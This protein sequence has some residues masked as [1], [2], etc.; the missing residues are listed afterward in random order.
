M[1]SITRIKMDF[2][3]A[4]DDADKIDRIASEMKKLSR[5]KL[6]NSMSE[7]ASV[8]TGA[9]SRMFLMKEQEFQR[10]IEKTAENL[11][12]IADDIR[13]IAK[14]IYDAERQAYNIVSGMGGR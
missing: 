6:D 8:W 11:N 9:N 13:K 3:K 1:K 5:N 12:D 7:L 14:R 4:K 10:A 2:V